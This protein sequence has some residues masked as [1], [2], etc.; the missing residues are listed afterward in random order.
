MTNHWIDMKHA[1]IIMIMGSNA[2]ENH[3]VSMKWIAIAKENGAKIISA[4]P[5]FTRTSSISDLYCPFRS[6]TDIA[7]VGGMINYALQNNLIQEEYVQNYTNAGFL[8]TPDYDF[9]DG[10]FSGYDPDKRKYDKSKWEYQYDS[11]GIP[12]MDRTLKNPRTVY[13]L[14][15]K[16]FS[17]YDFDTVSQ[18]TGAPKDKFAEICK[19][20]TSTS[21]RDKVGT[22][23]YAMGTTQHTHGTQNIRTYA[24]LQLLMGNMGM[25][26]GGVNALRG[27]SNVQGSTDHCLL[28]HILPGY[29]KAPQKKDKSLSDYIEAYAPKTHD[30]KSANW[31][32]NYSKYIV[33]LLKAWYGENANK[34]ND[35]VYDY[36][37]KR[38]GNSI[39]S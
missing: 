1:D 34:N 12:K 4:D 2:A 17:R 31:W 3:P 10:L 22:W 29:L 28:F 8:I 19:L 21:Q 23:L 25:A 11:D 7:F 13:Q 35:F 36:L 20:Y 38:S 27:E 32:G 30:P 14:M 33:S 26:G 39:F 9:N 37:P 16:H 24:I 15:K 6:G 5:R 18:I